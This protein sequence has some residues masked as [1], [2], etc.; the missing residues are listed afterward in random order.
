MALGKVRFI[1]GDARILRGDGRE[2]ALRVGDVVNPGD[3]VRL[4][5]AAGLVII[6]D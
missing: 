4:L 1:R 6:E 5:T 3:V 2:E